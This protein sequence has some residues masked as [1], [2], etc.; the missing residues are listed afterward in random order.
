MK[1]FEK[2]TNN[3]REMSLYQGEDLSYY[4]NYLDEIKDSKKTL[5]RFTEEI[6]KIKILL[7]NIN[8]SNI[9]LNNSKYKDNI[10]YIINFGK[11]IDPLIFTLIN[12][13][14]EIKMKNELLYKKLNDNYFNG[15][16]MNISF[17]V[18]INRD[19]FNK[20]HFPFDLPIFFKN[21]GLGKKIIL[22][23]ILDF[24]F[25]LF[26]KKD[27]SFELKIT[28]DSI[29]ENNNYFSFM[30]D[31]NILIFVDNF[32]L[33]K[34]KL[35]DWFKQGYENYILNKDFHIKYKEEIENDDF[36]NKIYEIYN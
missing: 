22:K 25:C 2:F 27:D 36:L 15:E 7:T 20:F 29:T 23:S 30:K 21:I 34:N 35:N 19:N 9:E 1:T 4:D 33:I 8:L 5:K 10:N 14:K 11:N 16:E 32:E 12:F 6:N 3:L 26:T 24:N 17:D 31:S 13:Y 28:V 18:E